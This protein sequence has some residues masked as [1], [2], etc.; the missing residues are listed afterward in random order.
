MAG[1]SGHNLKIAQSRTGCRLPFES[2]EGDGYACSS[3]VKVYHLTPEEVAAKYGPPA[4]RQLQRRHLTAGHLLDAIAAS[5]GPEEAAELIGMPVVRFKTECTLRGIRKPQYG[6]P[7]K[8]AEN[9]AS[10]EEFNEKL[11]KD[12]YMELKK[13]GL[14]DAKILEA[15]GLNYNT[16]I[17]YLTKAK[18]DWGLAGLNLKAFLINEEILNP[19]QAPQPELETQP[20]AQQGETET[21]LPGHGEQ[22]NDDLEP[23]QQEVAELD[24]DEPGVLI[25][26]KQK[27][28]SHLTLSLNSKGLQLNSCLAK[29]MH[30]QGV[31]YVRIEGTASGRIR[32]YPSS[33]EINCFNVGKG[34]KSSESLRMG[35]GA[36]ARQLAEIGVKTGKHQ[37][38]WNE[39]RGRW[40]TVVS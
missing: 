33:T 30:A 12:V 3:A 32:L 11:T 28:Y 22:I 8:E 24:D 20:E 23:I 19:P 26:P 27:N 38:E 10:W 2:N 37:L 17:N 31:K 1:Q 35:G 18:K 29:A 14:S 4:P 15:A 5:D 40:E 6:I 21:P 34:K 9:V 16:Y 39:R 7:R 25:I 36:L 13:Q